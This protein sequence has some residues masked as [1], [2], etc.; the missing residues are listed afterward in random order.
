VGRAVAELEFEDDDADS[1]D[2]EE[3]EIYQLQP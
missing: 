2:L 1:R 3:I